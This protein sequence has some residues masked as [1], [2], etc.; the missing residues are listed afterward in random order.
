MIYSIN[1]SFSASESSANPKEVATLEL[2]AVHDSAKVGDLLE[3]QS[4]VKLGFLN[5]NDNLLEKLGYFG[6][7]FLL[8]LNFNSNSV[9]N[10]FFDKSKSFDE[11]GENIRKIESIVGTHNSGLYVNVDDIKSLDGDKKF[12]DFLLKFN[13]FVVSNSDG[14]SEKTRICFIINDDVFNDSSLLKFQ[15]VINQTKLNEK[16]L[17]AIKYQSKFEGQIKNL[18][19]ST[20]SGYLDIKRNLLE[21]ILES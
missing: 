14:C 4:D 7:H 6:Y 10:L 9:D 12:V 8:N 21:S 13:P 3:L 16:W 18:I 19:N 15:E 5:F 17:I 1:F 20:N 2:L 11:N